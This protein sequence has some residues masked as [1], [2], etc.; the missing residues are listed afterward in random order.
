MIRY[1]L[2]HDIGTS[3]NKAALFSEEGQ[4][5]TQAFAPY[6]TEYSRE[7]WAEQNPED[8][9]KAV[10]ATTKKICAQI[11]RSQ[12]A[13]VSFCG[14]SNGC[15]CLDKHG[16]LLRK[17]MIH[18]DQ[19]AVEQVRQ[20]R[21][22]VGD[23]AVYEITGNRLS[24]SFTLEKF[25][26]V[27]KN[28]PDVYRETDKV[29]NAKDYLV[30]KLTGK[31]LTDTTDASMTGAFDI[32]GRCWSQRLIDNTGISG[33]MFPDIYPS[34]FVAG[35]IGGRIAREIGLK[36]GTPVVL[37]AGDGQ[38]G[39]FGVAGIEMDKFYN[40]V[41][42]SSTISVAS[43]RLFFDADMKVMINCHPVPGLYKFY[44]TMQSAGT[45][46]EW[47]KDQICVSESKEARRKRIS[48]YYLID[49][50]IEKSP[51]GAN[52][53]IFL[54]YL[55]GERSPYWN[56]DAKGAFIGIRASHQR[57]DILRAV[58][59]GV[60]F[61]MKIN[62]R[63][64]S[65]VVGLQ[66][67]NLIVYGGGAKGRVW[68]QIMAD[69]FGVGVSHPDPIDD[70]ASIGAAILGG[71]GVGI[72]QDYNINDRFI[73]AGDTLAP[74]RENANLYQKMQTIFE[75]SYAALEG[76]FGEQSAL[77]VDEG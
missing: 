21:E 17:A 47:L 62:L 12:I 38:C 70:G 32:T 3:G 68:R 61:N 7:Y 52:G 63:T 71:I 50:E 23:L 67:S 39:F 65:Q 42:S 19:R 41:G 6:P 25:L 15:V 60:A 73:R 57:E 43:Q 2:T 56:P 53:V 69:I 59:E 30:R 9:W 75:H 54:P 34:T 11:D 64:I 24:P 14:H 45:A 28:E 29:L 51:P 26:W 77:R 20:I 18:S 74:Q 55:L 48:A 66:T 8:W 76:V 35:E 13:V 37:G 31:S 58:L 22:K 5:V 4:L 27:K 44:T 40:Y 49:Q 16:N 46:Y 10:C 72:Y 1:I 33:D 36:K